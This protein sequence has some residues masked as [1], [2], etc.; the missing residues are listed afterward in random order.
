MVYTTYDLW[1]FGRCFMIL[2]PAWSPNP[3]F[4]WAESSYFATEV[5]HP[6][7]SHHLPY[8]SV[9]LESSHGHIPKDPLVSFHISPGDWQTGRVF[10]TQIEGLQLFGQGG[11]D[12]AY[13][14]PG[15]GRLGPFIGI[16][17][18]KNTFSV[19]SECL[20][21]SGAKLCWR[22]SSVV[23]RMEKKDTCWS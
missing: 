12:I 14:S 19:L 23:L 16:C 1:W 9:Q 20:W 4:F 7:V 3:S 13:L 17:W 5:L 11:L 10:G 18:T 2:S 21:L 22:I 8:K 6:L 15:N